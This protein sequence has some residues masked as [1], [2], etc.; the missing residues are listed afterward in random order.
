MAKPI[1][2]VS[3]FNGVLDWDKI[4]SQIDGAIIRCGY[5]GNIASQDDPQYTRNV[6][7]CTRLGI[8]FGVY[9]FSYARNA[10]EARDEAEHVLRLVKGWYLRLPIYYDLEQNDVVKD[11]SSGQYSEIARA[12]GKRIEA[13]GGFVGIYSNLYLWQTKLDS[14]N[15]FT[16]WLAQWSEAP[17][18]AKPFALWQYTSSGVVDGSSQRT[19]L[20]KWY[21]NFLTMV[22]THNDFRDHDV[23][24]QPPKPV[25]SYKIGDTV[26][27]RALYRASDSKEPIT[28][29]AITQGKITRIIADAPNP[30][31]INNGTGWVNDSVITKQGYSALQVN[32]RV[33]V[34]PG[35]KDVNGVALA[36]FVYQN[37]YRV[38]EVKGN[39]IVI[40]KDNQVTAAVAAENLIKV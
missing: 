26:S 11:I 32:D 28:D 14:V 13:A 37:V 17:T 6:K 34:K 3:E 38:M 9:L 25:L 21:G 10:T 29:I 24:P 31:L 2:D 18:Y 30:Y 12:F 35:A 40:G 1:I 15:E 8:P 23:K 27:F 16:R 4:K 33:K 7:E 19:D 22:G 39:R 36:P 20:S 5:G